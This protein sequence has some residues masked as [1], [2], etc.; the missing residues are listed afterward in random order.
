MDSY[1]RLFKIVLV[2]D[3][4]VGKSSLLSRFAKDTFSAT[5][6][7]TVGVDFAARIVAMPDGKRVKAQI[8]D[9]SGQERYR[10][11]D[12]QCYRGALGVLLVYDTT[13]ASSLEDLRRWMK[14]IKELASKDIVL[15]MV[16]NKI[17]LG[18]A[19]AVSEEQAQA[20]ALEL[21]VPRAETSAL[22]GQNVDQAFA[23]LLERIY[24]AAL[25]KQGGG[26]G[27]SAR[28]SA[29]AAVAPDAG[30]APRK[31]LA[32]VQHP[33]VEVVPSRCGPAAEPAACPL[34]PANYA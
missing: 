11:L 22:T 3:D 20:M 18:S 5:Q 27:S 4:G 33:R 25:A 19:R 17:D 32:D 34:S 30:V 21:D 13:K 14:E 7:S 23:H 8:W 24:Q 12:V 1:D 29:L 28:G 10:A 2:G 16:G 9:T 26:G 31:S 15:M 6:R